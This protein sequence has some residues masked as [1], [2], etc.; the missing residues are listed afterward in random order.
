MERIKEN[1]QMERSMP[2]SWIGRLGIAFLPITPYIQCRWK[3][4]EI[5]FVNI[6]KLT[7]KYKW[8]GHVT[9][10]QWTQIYTQDLVVS[11]LWLFLLQYC[12]D[13]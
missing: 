5:D 3:I 7:L 12:A 1:S 13:Y 2:Y 8:K 9:L 10:S 6:V 4:P 11:V